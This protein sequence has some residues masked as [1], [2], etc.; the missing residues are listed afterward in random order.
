M[1][2]PNDNDGSEYNKMWYSAKLWT[3]TMCIGFLLIQQGKNVNFIL[4]Q[5]RSQTRHNSTVCFERPKLKHDVVPTIGSNSNI[6]AQKC[7]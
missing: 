2:K 5:I 1:Q 3:K 7:E 4:P 6:A